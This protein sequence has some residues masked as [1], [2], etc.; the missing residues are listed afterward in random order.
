MVGVLHFG[1][2]TLTMDRAG[3][4]EATVDTSAWSNGLHPIS[5]TLCDG[6]DN[7]HYDLG[8]VL[9]AH[10]TPAGGASGSAGGAGGA[11]GRAGAGGGGGAGGVGGAGH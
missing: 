11:P 4:F 10:A 7:V 5:A 1:E 8:N 9:V 6:W 3:S 2:A